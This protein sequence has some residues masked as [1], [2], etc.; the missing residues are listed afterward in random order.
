[1]EKG[2]RRRVQED[3]KFGK[4]IKALREKC[5]YSMRQFCEGLRTFQETACLESGK[6]RP[7]KLLQDA[8]LERLGV[9]S[10]DREHFLGYVAYDRWKIRQRITLLLLNRPSGR[11]SFWRN[12]PGCTAAGRSVP[13]ECGIPDECGE[14][15]SGRRDSFILA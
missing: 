6:H 5:G 13:Q 8:V 2:V 7:E 10:E 4:Y 14:W 12:T 1:M 3:L 9:G 11:R 15:R